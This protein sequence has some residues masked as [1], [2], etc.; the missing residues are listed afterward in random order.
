M[1]IKCKNEFL[2]NDEYSLLTIN[3][4]YYITKEDKDFVYVTDDT[5]KNLMLSKNKTENF[6]N[7]NEFFYTKQELRKL[8]IDKFLDEAEV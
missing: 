6:V 7:L 5:G 3:R 4:W 1:N 2:V 8:K